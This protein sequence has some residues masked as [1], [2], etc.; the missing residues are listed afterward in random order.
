MAWLY[1]ADRW[2]LFKCGDIF[3]IQPLQQQNLTKGSNILPC[4]EDLCPFLPVQTLLPY[5]S[6]TVNLKSFIGKDFLWN[7]W[8]YKLSYAL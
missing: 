1:V 5:R 4:E 3:P 8:K 7:K 6:Q 2:N